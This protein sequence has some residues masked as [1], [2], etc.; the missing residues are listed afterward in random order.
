V[1]LVLID[2]GRLKEFQDE[3]I[4]QGLSVVTLKSRDDIDL[5]RYTKRAVVLSAADYV[6]GL[7]FDEV[8]VAGFPTVLP[9]E[10]LSVPQQR[11]ILAALYVAVSRASLEVEIH[12]HTEIGDIASLLQRA[13]AAGVLESY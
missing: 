3:T 4:K 6:A 1:A 10:H 5:L 9:S 13:A 2:D 8:L 11:R 7:Q 12:I